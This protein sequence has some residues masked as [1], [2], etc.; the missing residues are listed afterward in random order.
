MITRTIK[1]FVDW[2]YAWKEMERNLHV[3]GLTKDTFQAS[4][5]ST[6]GLIRLIFDSI[7]S[8][9][10][11]CF[12]CGMFQTDDLEKRFGRYRGL[13]GYNYNVSVRQIM[14]SEKK[15]RIRT[16]ISKFPD[17]FKSSNYALK[18]KTLS[19]SHHSLT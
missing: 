9:T 7:L 6:E 2:L 18:R 5:C 8:T 12:L 15:L 10:I 1:K 17:A 11:E 14:E 19:T 13:S 4:I 16:L 3:G